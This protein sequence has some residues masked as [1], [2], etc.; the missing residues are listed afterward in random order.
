M[1][2]NVIMR[3]DWPTLELLAKLQQQTKL[4]PP[5][6]YTKHMVTGTTYWQDKQDRIWV[7]TDC[8]DM[9]RAL[10]AAAHQGPSGHR[11]VQTTMAIL[12]KFCSWKN[13]ANDIE[14]F[15]K[16]C[17][18]CI[19][20]MDGTTVTRPLGEQL[21]AEQLGVV[22]C[23]AGMSAKVVERVAWVRHNTTGFM[24]PERRS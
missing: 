12:G 13:M 3:Q 6:T 23:Q 2:N 21:V 22:Q 9:K 8:K 19:H 15:R 14:T 4:K 16:Q 17:L 5:R 7:P 24:P 18:Q 10:F 11:G 1:G 20:L